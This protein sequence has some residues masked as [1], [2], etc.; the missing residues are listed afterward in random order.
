M[1]LS[2]TRTFCV[3]IHNK[4][5][6]ITIKWNR[7]RLRKRKAKRDKKGIKI[8]KIRKSSEKTEANK[9]RAWQSKPDRIKK[10]NQATK[11]LT[12][13]KSSRRCNL[14]ARSTENS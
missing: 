9:K 14:S 3:V 7:R 5:A 2:K 8:N 10:R 6:S 11:D 12:E 1:Q 4:L 13:R